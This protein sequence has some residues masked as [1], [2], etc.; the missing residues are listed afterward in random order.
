MLA[1]SEVKVFRISERIRVNFQSTG[2]A[3]GESSWVHW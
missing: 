1:M 2:K 3:C